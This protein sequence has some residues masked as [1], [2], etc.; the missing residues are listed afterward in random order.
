MTRVLISR[1]ERSIYYI[2]ALVNDWHIL[3]RK[4]ARDSTPDS[5]KQTPRRKQYSTE[6][7]TSDFNNFPSELGDSIYSRDDWMDIGIA[8]ALIYQEV[9]KLLRYNVGAGPIVRKVGV[10][11]KPYLESLQL[12]GNHQEQMDLSKYILSFVTVIWDQ[13][14][15]SSSPYF[16]ASVEVELICLGL[17]LVEYLAPILPDTSILTSSIMEYISDSSVTFLELVSSVWL[18]G[19]SG[20]DS[21]K[22][23][24]SLFQISSMRMKKVIAVQGMKAKLIPEYLEDLKDCVFSSKPYSNSKAKE[25]EFCK[26]V[27][28][29]WSNLSAKVLK[30]YVPYLSAF[31]SLD[32]G[33][34][35]N[36]LLK[37]V[38]LNE[39]E[40]VFY[41]IR[42][43]LSRDEK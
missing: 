15:A 42:G 43:L 1:V 7:F 13:V 40:Q 8:S 41:H 35:V 17:E 10:F 27:L 31:Y 39:N 30:P 29:N 36:V 25:N 5:P 26:K 28:F 11:L 23:L 18:I 9:V 4:L 3:I 16:V 33:R 12:N 22:A 14:H 6:T 19:G 37:K 32:E 2:S 38:A 34:T 20:K 24:S 21:Y